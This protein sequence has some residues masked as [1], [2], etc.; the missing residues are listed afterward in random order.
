[1]CTELVEAMVCKVLVSHTG[2]AEGERSICLWWWTGA[3]LFTVNV[4]AG[5]EGGFNV[6]IRSTGAR[7]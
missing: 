3:P 7:G 1:M 4:S 5:K 6:S 2:G